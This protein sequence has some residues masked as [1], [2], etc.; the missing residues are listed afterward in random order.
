MNTQTQRQ[1]PFG[2][3]LTDWMSVATYREGGWSAS[4]IERT[5]AL[6]LH[7]AAHALHYGS[8][9]FEGFK[10]YRRADGGVHIFRL[11]A[12]IERMRQSARLLYMPEPDAARLAEMVVALVDRCRD[13]VPAAPG[14]LY[15]R[16]VLFGTMANIGA[17]T[18]PTQEAS[19][20]VLASPVWDYFAGGA[21][22]LK[23]YVSLNPRTA[24][25]LGVVKTGGNYAAALGPTLDAR[26]RYS[27]DQVLFCPNGEVQETGAANFLLIR[28]R[29]ILTRSLDSTFLHG[30]TRDSLL[31]LAREMGYAVSER[32]L[33]IDE[34]LAWTREGEAALSGTAAVLAG[35]GTLVHLG[36]EHR[37]GSGEVGPHTRAL[38]EAL[39][40][41]QRGESADRFGWLTAV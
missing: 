24:P 12:H 4:R 26:A 9:C 36:R 15:L 32:V 3:V 22:G 16:P 7:P 31:T 2:S 25:H 34:A 17:A 29:E 28:E 1:A 8:S 14:A 11:Q 37:V 41:V 6:P 30:V 10:A 27:A 23:I 40:K 20:I 13:A 21:K 39:V 18:Q 33:S 19:L 5:A 38:R 35:V